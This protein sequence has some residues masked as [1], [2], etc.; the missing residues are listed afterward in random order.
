MTSNISIPIM[1]AIDISLCIQSQEISPSS[2]WDVCTKKRK[3]KRNG[4]HQREGITV[5]ARYQS[6]CLFR[7]QISL[8]S[9]AYSQ[10]PRGRGEERETWTLDW[11]S[12]D[13]QDRCV[14]LVVFIVIYLSF[15]AF[16]SWTISSWRISSARIMPPL[17][18]STT[19]RRCL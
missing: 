8:G 14:Q 10:P 19:H 5:S 12:S 18:S 1:Q 13:P 3:R 9:L 15:V 2:S 11:F 7:M 4:I 16:F 6:L 17:P